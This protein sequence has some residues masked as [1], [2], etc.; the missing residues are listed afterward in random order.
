MLVEKQKKLNR[1]LIASWE[2]N[3][4]A[5]FLGELRRLQSQPELERREIAEEAAAIGAVIF[6]ARPYSRSESGGEAD[7]RVDANEVFELL[8]SR[9]DMEPLRVVH[10]RLLDLRNEATAHGDWTHHQTWA[11]AEHG[12]VLVV[13][14]LSTAL[15]DFE[16]IERLIHEMSLGISTLIQTLAPDEGAEG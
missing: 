8:S 15:P 14:V 2:L 6:Y 12:R 3:R 16:Q 11:N 13:P 1:L 7:R 4:A 9:G 10:K 5:D